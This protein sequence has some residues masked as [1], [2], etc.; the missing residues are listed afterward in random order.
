MP[1]SQSPFL[2]RLQLE[3]EYSGYTPIEVDQSAPLVPYVPLSS[4][5]P[6]ISSPSGGRANKAS[7]LKDL[8]NYAL[9]GK[10]DDGKLVGGG[11]PRALSEMTSPR[12]NNFTPDYNNEDAYAQG[13]GWT[14]KMINGVGKGLLLTGTTFLQT[15]LG[16][17]NG[18]AR[19]IEDGRAA[20]FYD[21]EFNRA[22]DEINKEAENLLPNYYKDVEKDASWYSPTKLVTAN[23]FWDGIVK[24]LGFAA[25]AAL[26]G[27]VYTTALRALPLTSR[28]FSIGKAADALAATEE[29][30]LSAN[31]VA[32]TYGKVKSLSDK[33][34]SSYNVLN[35]GGRALVA[36][37]ATT[38]EAGFEAY[39]NLNE[40]RNQ[41]IQE[42]KDSHFGQDPIGEDLNRINAEADNVGNSSFLLN[43]AL[44]TA[45]NYIQFPKILGSSYKTEKGIVNSL[46]KEIRDV[47]LNEAG[48]FAEKEITTRGGRILSS[49]DKGR[50]YL[51]S[52]SEGFEEGSQYAIQIGTQDYYNKKYNNQATNFLESLSV[53]V[54]KTLTTDEGMENVLIGGLSGAIMLGRGKFKESSEINR[55]TIDAIQR[56]NKFTLSDFTKETIASVNRGTVLQEEREKAVKEGNVLKSKDLETDYI[57]NYLSPRIKYGRWDLVQ[58]DIHDYKT[59]A[60]TEEGFAQLQAEGKALPNDSRQA[61]LQRI[62]SLEET[63]K[64]VSSLYQSLNLR[65]GNYVDNAGNPLYSSEV[66]DKMVYS[67]TKVADYDK[68]ITSLSG[69]LILAGVDTSS[70]IDDVIINNTPREESLR[71]AITT[72]DK[73]NV[74]S[75]VKSELKD[76]LIDLIDMSL[77]RQQYL[78]EYNDIKNSPQEFKESPLQEPTIPSVEKQ[79][80]VEIDTK[81]GKEEIE[82]GTEYF[83][84]RV[85]EKNAKGKDVYRAPK[86]TIL[87]ENENGTIRIQD[88]KGVRDVDKSVLADYKLG[89]VEDTLKNKKAKFFMDNWNTIFEF[90]FGKG[91]TVNG[92]LEYSPKKGVLNFVYK[93]KKDEIKTIEV[94]GDQF[95]PK[96]GY[97]VP[98]IKAIGKLSA[99]QQESLDKFAAETEEDSLAENENLLEQFLGTNTNDVQS[100]IENNSYQAESKKSDLNVVSSTIPPSDEKPF[101]QRANRF[102][103]RFHSLKNRDD[104]K[105]IVVTQKTE[106]NILP[107]LTGLLTNNGADADPSSVIALVMVVEE[108]GNYTLVDENG[109][110]IESNP[111]DKAIFQ[112]FP[113]SK[114]EA[115]YNGKKESMFRNNTPEYIEKALRE[116]YD[117][118]RTE[119]LDSS[120]LGDAQSIEASF[121]IP[122]YVTYTLSSGETKTDYD[123]QIP[124]EETGLITPS[125]LKKSPVV[126]VATTNESI[127]N[128]SVTFNTPLGRVF[129]QVPG[130]L[131]KLFNKKLTPEKA[132]VVYEAIHQLS[133][134]ATSDVDGVRSTNS[135]QILDWLKSTIYW[136]IAKD[137]DTG[138]R[139]PAGYNNVWFERVHDEK[140]DKDVTKLF[141]SGMG[142]GFY[143]TPASIEANKDQIINLLSNLYHN[144]SATLVNDKKFNDPY[145]EITSFEEDGKPVVKKWDNYQTYLL[146]AKGRKKEEIPL[147][148]I[149][150]PLKNKEDVNRK[151][152][153]FTLTSSVDNFVIPKEPPVVKTSKKKPQLFS[154]PSSPSEPT[155]TP[156]KE[157]NVSTGFILDG[158][159]KNTIDN[160]SL[161]KIVFAATIK[162][163]ILFFEDELGNLDEDTQKAVDTLAA[164]KNITKEK[165]KDII[166]ASLLNKIKP[167]VVAEEIPQEPPLADEAPKESPFKKRKRNLFNPDDK[168]YRMQLV[169]EV[170][171]FQGEDWNKVEDWLKANF[172]NLPVYRVKNMI[173]ATNGRQ[174]WGMLQNASIYITQNA[175]IGTA[176]HEVFEA[177]WKMFS[178]QEER[179]DILNEFQNRKG[180]FE[181]RFTGKTINYFDATPSQIKEELAEE[182]RDFV[183]Y[184]KLPARPTNGKNFIQRMFNE[185]V[186]FIREFFTGNKAQINTANLFSKIGNGYYKEYIPYEYPLS[187]AET[188]II[189]ID[190][191]VGNDSAE[192]RIANI[193]STQVHEIMQQLTYSTLTSLTRN[194]KSLFSIPKLN[195]EKLYST[196]K[197]ETL[198]LIG[199]QGDLIEQAIDRKEITAKEAA[200]RYNALEL[201]YNN[202]EN[203]WPSLINK[204]EEYLKTYSIEFDENGETILNDE[205][206]SG[207]SDYQDARKI[208]S[209]RATNSAVKLLIAT[210]PLTKSSGKG[211]AR[212][213]SVVRSSIGGVTLINSDKV[214]ITLMNKLHTSTNIDDMLNRLRNL[215]LSDG[216]YEALYTRLTKSS[217]SI[218]GI[219]YSKL[220][221][222]F[223]VQLLT[224]LWKTFKKQN[225]DVKTVFIFPT[226]EIVFGD[227]SMSTAARQAKWEIFNDVIAKIKTD[228]PYVKYS[229]KTKTYESSNVAKNYKLDAAK[230][231]T[232]TSFLRGIGIEFTL[233][234]L[235]K[236]NNS[237]LNIFRAAVEGIKD[238]VSKY[239]DI[240]TLTRRSLNIDG[241][242]LQLGTIKAIIENPEFE[243]T[244]FNV[245]GDRVQ[246]F[247]G[248]NV[249]SNLYDTIS[250]IKNIS[251]LANTDYSYLLTDVFSKG[252]SVLSSIFDED[253]ERK[254]NTFDILKS[255]YVDGTVNEATNK[256]KESSRLTYKERLIQEIN[257]NLEGWYMNLVPGDASIEW[258]IKLGNPISTKMLGFGFA[259]VEE[260]FKDYF[261]S[262]LNLSREERPIVK[263]G[264]RTSKDLRFFKPILGDALHNQIINKTN[265]KL[266]PEKVYEK[267]K[268][269]INS[270][271]EDFIREDMNSLRTTLEQYGVVYQDEEG[272]KVQNL[273]FSEEGTITDEE[274]NLNLTA[275]SVNYMIANVELHKLIYSDPY[276]YKDELKR[277]KNFNSPR[278]PLVNNSANI[279]ELINRVYNEG[280]DVEDIGYSDMTREYMNSVAVED[281]LSS[282]DLPDYDVWKETDGGGYISMKANRKFRI[283]ASDWNE[284]E[285]RQYKY[286]VAYEKKIKNIPLSESEREILKSNPNIRSAYTPL[287]PIVAGN[288]EDNKDYNDVVLDKFALTPLSFRV[289]HQLNPTS[290]AIK[291]YNKLQEEDVDYVVY[292]S[293]RKVGAGVLSPLYNEDGTFNE[294]PFNE[295]NKIPFSIIG[296]QAE[297]PSKDTPSVTQGSQVTKLAT[298]D[299][300][301]AG[302]PIDFLPE[303]SIEDRFTKWN[304]LKEKDKLKSSIYKEIKNNQSILEARIE[305][306]YSILLK[307]LGISQNEEGFVISDVDKLI[308]TLSSEILKREVN[309]NITD[310]FRGFKD[311]DVVLEATPAYQQIR[312]I[313]YSISDRNVVRPKISGGLKVQ[314][315]STLLESNRVK[316]ESINNKKAYTSDV[317][318]FYQDEDGKRVAEIMVAKWFKSSMSDDKL[319]DYLNNTKEGQKALSGIGFRIP[320][321]KQNSIEVF[322][323]KKFLPNEF[324]DSVVIPSAL[325]KKVG[326]DFDIDKLSIYLKNV[327][328]DGKGELKLIPYF[329]TGEQA[330]NNIKEFLI[331]EDIKYVLLSDREKNTEDVEDDYGTLAD[332]F[333][334]KSLEN[335]YIQSLENLV[336]HPLNFTQ[337]IK[338]NSAEQ[339][340]TLSNKIITS[341]GE[342][343]YNYSSTGSMLSRKFMSSLRQAFVSGKYAIGIAAVNQTNHAQNQRANI[344][345]DKDRINTTALGI[346][347]VK[348]LGDGEINFKKYNTLNGK[349]SLS[350]IKNANGEHI[351]D[352][353]G[354]FIDGYVD[355]SN[356]PW[357]MQLGAKPNV[358]STW[359]F[360]IKL[361]VPV[362]TVAYFMNQPIIRDYLR[363]I[364]D[365]GYSWLFIDTFVEEAL[366]RYD[367]S[368]TVVDTIPSEKELEDMLSKKSKDMSIEE[369]AQQRFILT[370]FLKYAKMAEHLFHVT[371][372]SNFDTAT[373]N[374]PYIVFKKQMQLEKARNTIISSV[375]DTLD[376]SF[377]G[378]LKNK[379]YDVRDAFS[380]I[381]MSDRKNVRNV[382]E[383]VLTPYIDLND[384]D[385]VKLAQKVVNDLFDWAVQNDRGLNTIIKDI[386][387]SSD[388]NTSTAQEIMELANRIKADNTHPLNKNVIMNSIKRVAGPK[389]LTPDNIQIIGRDNKVYDQNQ[390]I[391]GFN[392]LKNHLVGEEAKL[393]GKLVRLAVLQSGLTKSG[394]SF[395]SLI[396]YEDF[397]EIYNQTLYLLE[398]MPNLNEFY[399]LDVF[400][401]NNWNNPDVVPFMK[402]PWIKSKKGDWFYNI[403]IKFL[404]KPIKNAINRGDIPQVLKLSQYSREGNS[405]YVVYTWENQLSTNKEKNKQLKKEAKKNGDTSYI[406]RYLFKRVYDSNG[407]PLKHISQTGDRI[408]EDYVFKAINAWGYSFK[409]NEFY[410]QERPSVIDNDFKKIY[411]HTEREFFD[412]EPIETNFS[413][414]VEDSVIEDILYKKKNSKEK[415]LPLPNEA[416]EAFGFTPST[417]LTTDDFKC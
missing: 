87:G 36:G 374:D 347:D 125:V 334:K 400:Q 299:F 183:L 343:Q 218:A 51:F 30:L 242:L 89:K 104:I 342:Q 241:R 321:Q 365:A 34:L 228:S 298:L 289:L 194:N 399:T 97:S 70:I 189:D 280:Y 196:L 261:I 93:N 185:L 386:L 74:I 265:S 251:E 56:F 253:G 54:T 152:I 53:G 137:L 140:Y 45:T 224:A 409:G 143:F 305:E 270:E 106:N 326:S 3:E 5:T 213:T 327:F 200:K 384:R 274:L 65:Y 113:L 256:N 234:E 344:F 366:E 57:I 225:A 17:I 398:D 180:S 247:I 108:N 282:N 159:T 8:E 111:L 415:S 311:G 285:E 393:Y 250:N 297:V 252:S 122:E 128:G 144:T 350:F 290:N 223:D 357:I 392:E 7:S 277:I 369:K 378:F 379:I 381:L 145:Y 316:I 60:M 363:R 307:K 301:Q 267:Y 164:Q 324:G 22:I 356:G 63:A 304:S 91:K 39:N 118:W 179:N 77:N 355:I 330:K 319:I 119:I 184:K 323:I 214:Y 92:R 238:S 417:D 332:K 156:E 58:S 171:K 165:A 360:L 120:E 114:L 222:T 71:D 84:G 73:L 138:K 405:D 401:R 129:L 178:S 72:I 314:I 82:I 328:V 76:G 410:S 232:Y 173:E 336:S 380:T 317:L 168:A 115:S 79:E 349:P 109:K 90:N 412:N 331:Q 208:D 80:I 197:E 131:I 6:S 262:E 248:T 402:A 151:G 303:E 169:K 123:A 217:P 1:N 150:R 397:K 353:I 340:Q 391:Y 325:V 204:H 190:D 210:L 117:N 273:S 333:Y 411:K 162:G 149:I 406:N 318:S 175:E 24:N 376:N 135:K 107:G 287:K 46:S 396:P 32:D 26:S 136:G 181:D 199:H 295:I 383:K 88:S 358:A 283:R 320:T 49:I 293:S 69:D 130:G 94:T 215:A 98:M 95:I 230:L 269:E 312:N 394:I 27:S 66:M 322:K 102:G 361:G 83:L 345:I 146:S 38:G 163:G 382:V 209:F 220:T 306:G 68:R 61:Y 15:T 142:E 372:G 216:N 329:G 221:N 37:L 286:D 404:N 339:L 16:T 291:F 21:N 126:R 139:K 387:L 308:D 62:L 354:Q 413:G 13:Q 25:G 275:L 244:Y 212:S 395:T 260:I 121:G 292:A 127:S 235:R 67:A 96:E 414:E 315:P 388:D 47:S 352:I 148:T 371:Q 390:I 59:L 284:D 201:L 18:V 341:I 192:Y 219:D 368:S 408:Y 55:N 29:G 133:K 10:S 407:S 35:P 231:E 389:A 335:E 170:E 157:N 186:N 99:V 2:D 364:E 64:N 141:I 302:V 403:G 239:K 271:L 41:R 351:S 272:M 233:P 12:F 385:F 237:Q 240:K 153:Y 132:S 166:G 50:K 112:V 243:S 160:P 205:D 337:L 249:I 48:Q 188:G 9:S 258:M 161:G 227:S 187:F 377:V 191:V 367:V 100:V 370:E 4:P 195:K 254:D 257:S 211:S 31:K 103:A 85:V 14:S 309:D 202:V 245:N 266:S 154:E 167:Q 176:Y 134:N 81:D 86:I 300:M 158:K 359:L 236:L 279:G 416:A 259:E 44:L 276:Q 263:I 264:D 207:K 174:A 278:Q 373:I 338:P 11:I 226:G 375:D 155:P 28:L 288:K 43:T 246:T 193:P 348:W 33:F 147:T 42:Y 362:D 182:F 281:V 78:K 294:E 23:F 310:A 203:E 172:P 101:N 124:V 255:G 296:V 268:K 75:D 40:F 206:N 20:S 19:A 52:A 229:P 313:L 116:Q 105:G 346:Q 198:N 177:V 110:P